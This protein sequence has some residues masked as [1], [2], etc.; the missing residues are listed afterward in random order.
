M[1]RA[2][3]PGAM[4]ASR[5][6]RCGLAIVTTLAV[7][8]LSA[9]LVA[10]AQRMMSPPGCGRSGG[11]AGHERL[12]ASAAPAASVRRY[13]HR[14]CRERVVVEADDVPEAGLG[15]RAMQ[16]RPRALGRS[17][18][19]YRQH[20]VAGVALGEV[21]GGPAPAS[22]QRGS[23]RAAIPAACTSCS[24]NALQRGRP[25]R[26]DQR[27]DSNQTGPWS[28]SRPYFESSLL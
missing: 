13:S 6:P 11:L 24:I 5:A 4:R 21:P 19:V 23:R 18:A 26:R 7:F 3:R 14:V 28:R 1:I 27:T 17:V 15:E 8:E 16:R 12:R 10:S 20:R 22:P 9:A 2:H 25:P